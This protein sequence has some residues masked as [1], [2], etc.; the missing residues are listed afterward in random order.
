M[1]PVTKCIPTT[2]DQFLMKGRFEK[3]NEHVKQNKQTTNKQTN[4]QTE[5]DQPQ[6]NNNKQTNK[7]INSELDNNKGNMFLFFIYSEHLRLSLSTFSIS[8]ACRS[9]SDHMC[10]TK[11]SFALKYN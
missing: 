9:K 8:F 3:T 6:T 2:D 11:K 7:Q 1:K 4:K 5:P 10:P